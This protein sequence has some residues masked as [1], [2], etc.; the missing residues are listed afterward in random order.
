[1]VIVTVH[2]DSDTLTATVT[3]GDQHYR[4]EAHHGRWWCSCGADG[5]CIHADAVARHLAPKTPPMKPRS[6][7]TA[8]GK[9]G[10]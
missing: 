10:A 1:M 4:V 7:G 9:G 5:F 8:S 3:D 2:T 6:T